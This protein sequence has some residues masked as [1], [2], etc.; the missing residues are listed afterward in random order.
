MRF[1][2]G[3][4][5]T[6]THVGKL[7]TAN[8]TLLGS[9]TFTNETASGWQETSFSSPVAIRQTPVM[10]R[11]TTPALGTTSSTRGYFAATGKDSA[12]L[13]A[14]QNG[15]NG[16]GLYV[17]GPSA[18]PTLTFNSTNYWVDVVFQ[19]SGAPDTTPPLISGV[20][21]TPTSTDASI[22]WTTNEASDSIVDYG[23]DPSALTSR[24]SSPALTISHT[25]VLPSLN[26]ATTYCSGC[27][28]PTY[29]AMPRRRRR[30]QRRRPV[31]RRRHWVALAR[32]GP[33]PRRRRLGRSRTPWAS[34][35]A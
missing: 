34:S 21:A 35:S 32:S 12:P 16:N 2:K 18:F 1:Y 14:L 4:G 3:V 11:P 28:R 17:Y 33:P 5:N 26:N 30:F 9:M 13:H 6:G 24:I 25:V 29:P 15:V 8:G 10:W 31:S 7:W 19:T 27:G 23:T 20:G 22:T